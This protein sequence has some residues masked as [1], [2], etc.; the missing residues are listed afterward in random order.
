MSDSAK[1]A[2]V[3]GT[4]LETDSLGTVEVDRAQ[5]WGAQTQR[6]LEHFDFGS[7]QFPRG[8]IEAFAL[9]KKAAA[10][11]H[12]ALGKLSEEQAGLIVQVAMKYWQDSTPIS[13]RSVRGSREAAPR[14]I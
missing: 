14:P 1:P 11:S 7:D 8:F 5:L 3:S 12:R 10:L 13:F 9:V 6:A 2:S 4:R